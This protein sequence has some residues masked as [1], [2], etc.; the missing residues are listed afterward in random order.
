MPPETR[1]RASLLV[2]G[3]PTRTTAATV[4][5][6]LC[7]LGYCECDVATSLNG[8][9]VPRAAR[10]KA[11]LGPEDRIEIVAARQGG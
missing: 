1:K 9:F 8:A 4:A 7:E 10:G 3:E 5:E 6:L 11:R 2:N